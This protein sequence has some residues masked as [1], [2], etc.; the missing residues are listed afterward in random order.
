M[1]YID[2][3]RPYTVAIAAMKDVGNPNHVARVMSHEYLHGA[4]HDIGET[5]ASQDI[6]CLPSRNEFPQMSGLPKFSKI[7][8]QPRA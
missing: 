2:E 3:R 6:D 4:M 1:A 5:R 8:E 7:N